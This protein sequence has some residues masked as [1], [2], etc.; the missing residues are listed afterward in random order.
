LNKPVNNPNG[1]ISS[2][3]RYNI[4]GY[5]RRNLTD[6]VE[7]LEDMRIERFI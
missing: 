4:L 2:K 5:G 1:V 3:T 6:A 7:F